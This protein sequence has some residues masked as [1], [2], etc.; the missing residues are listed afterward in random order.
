VKDDDPAGTPEPTASE[1][2]TRFAT[3]MTDALD[4]WAQKYLPVFEQITVQLTPERLMRS[5]FEEFGRRM[6]EINDRTP[7]PTA[8]GQQ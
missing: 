8:G 4:A 6:A 1:A 2:L 3:S 5:A 7:R